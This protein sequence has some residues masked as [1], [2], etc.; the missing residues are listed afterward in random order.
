MDKE[1]TEVKASQVTRDTAD[2]PKIKKKKTRTKSP[3]RGTSK[4]R[5]ENT[6]KKERTRKR[7]KKSKTSKTETITRQFGM[8]PTRTCPYTVMLSLFVCTPHHHFFLA[9][10]ALH[11]SHPLTYALY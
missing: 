6:K 9:P 2:R 3:P 10:V 4:R 8:T 5:A 1:R 11:R 7:A